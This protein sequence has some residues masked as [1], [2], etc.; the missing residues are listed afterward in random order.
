MYNGFSATALGAFADYEILRQPLP[1]RDDRVFTMASKPD[2]QPAITYASHSYA[3]AAGAQTWTQRRLFLLVEHGG[4]TEIVDLHDTTGH[5]RASFLGIA[6]DRA[7][8]ILLA[9]VH[10][11]MTDHIHAA[12]AEERNRWAQGYLAGRIRKSRPRRGRV[13][14]RVETEFERDLRR[15]RAE[16]R[17][18]TIDLVAGEIRPTEPGAV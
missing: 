3:L 4:G 7:L 2:G 12:V 9:S 8:Y 15:G 5:A 17:S 1:H 18:V 14:V 16:P 13:T 6:D 11:A 10:H